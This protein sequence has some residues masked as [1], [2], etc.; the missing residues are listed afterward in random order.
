MA[1][2]IGP[3]QGNG[4]VWKRGPYTLGIW[5][6]SDQGGFGEPLVLGYLGTNGW[7]VVSTIM[8]D[9]PG[10]WQNVIDTQYGG[11]L[12]RFIMERCV[13]NIN[14]EL[15]T[16]FPLN[17]YANTPVPPDAKYSKD[18][19]NAAIAQYLDCTTDGLLKQKGT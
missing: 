18:A 13:K 17:P 19:T 1:V 12:G 5:V 7:Q 9:T 10:G 15:D 14:L 8:E 16:F 11:S 2:D 6:E 3:T 4:F